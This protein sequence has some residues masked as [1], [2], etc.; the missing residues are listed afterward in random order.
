MAVIPLRS[1][2][3]NTHKSNARQT[4]RRLEDLAVGFLNRVQ[5]GAIRSAYVFEIDHD[6]RYSE[7]AEFSR[8]DRGIAFALR[9]LMRGNS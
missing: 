1:A 6:S 8:E 2:A 3:I 7:T 4:K 5:T 9:D